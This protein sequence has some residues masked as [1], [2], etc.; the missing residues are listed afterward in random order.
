MFQILILNK[1]LKKSY[2]DIVVEVTIYQQTVHLSL[3]NVPEENK[4]EDE[5]F[6][7][8]PLLKD[9]RW[10]VRGAAS[11]E[12]LEMVPLPEKY[13][14][15]L[16]AALRFDRE[17]TSFN[18]AKI[19]GKNGRKAIIPKLREALNSPERLLKKAAIEALEN[20]FSKE[21]INER[22]SHE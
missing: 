9:K 21:E 3:K 18:C 13:D 4:K 10:W 5:L 20:Y 19:L 6:V 2:G 14:N 15:D 12:L 1:I 11:I 7:I 22:S 16:C 17:F 8:V